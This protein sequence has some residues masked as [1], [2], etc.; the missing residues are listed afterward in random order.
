MHEKEL[1]IRHENL[2]HGVHKRSVQSN[3]DQRCKN[4]KVRRAHVNAVGSFISMQE[5]KKSSNSLTNIF[6]VGYTYY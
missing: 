4:C 6:Y 3:L 5:K 2:V 1:K